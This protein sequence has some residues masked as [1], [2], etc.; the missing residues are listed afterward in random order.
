MD[1][2]VYINKTNKVKP[3]TLTPDRVLI[4]FYV[5]SI[6]PNNLYTDNHYNY[7][8]IYTLIK[9]SNFPY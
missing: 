1:L 4:I 3:A 2:T 9:Q 5:T 7:Q 8:V 6:Y